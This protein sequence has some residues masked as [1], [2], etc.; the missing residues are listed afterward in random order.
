MDGKSLSG[1]FFWSFSF[2]Y[3][4]IPIQLSSRMIRLHCRC[5]RFEQCN[6]IIYIYIWNDSTKI[7]V[8]GNLSLYY[9]FWKMLYFF[10]I[11]YHLIKT[12]QRILWTLYFVWSFFLRWFIHRFA[13]LSLWRWIRWIQIDHSF[14]DTLAGAKIVTA[15]QKKSSMFLILS[16]RRTKTKRIWNELYNILSFSFLLKL[17]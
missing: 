9:W 16:Q 6:N 7:F 12:L 13:Y 1:H 3:T 8:V 4:Y 10:G 5:L 15:L 11:L 2:P 14:V 17:W